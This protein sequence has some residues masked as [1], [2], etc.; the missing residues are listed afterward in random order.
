MT[1]IDQADRLER[2]ATPLL[3]TDPDE[4]ERL[5]ALA[6]EHRAQAWADAMTW[7]AAS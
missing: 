2:Q 1:E 5:L 7:R 6:D 3:D 4:A